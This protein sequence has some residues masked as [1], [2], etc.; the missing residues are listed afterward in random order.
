MQMGD[1][2][3]GNELH[4]ESVIEE[5]KL[6]DKNGNEIE[7]HNEVTDFRG[8]KAVVTGIYPPHKE[9]SSG[10]VEVD[11]GNGD[12][13]FLYATVF[14]LKYVKQDTVE[15]SLITERRWNYEE[16]LGKELRDYIEQ[17]DYE[18][19]LKTIYNIAKK[20]EEKLGDDGYDFEELAHLV[21]NEW[22]IVDDRVELN[23]IGFDSPEDLIDERLEM[24]YDAC[25][26]N[27]IFLSL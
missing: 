18:N 9:S 15:E 10:H 11:Y 13:R 4:N 20:Y 8:D 2:N 5:F 16:P 24:L 22:E 3:K 19:V 25:D 17:E 26:N 14:G 7:I 1:E 12:V 27:D 21:E 6:V 23:E